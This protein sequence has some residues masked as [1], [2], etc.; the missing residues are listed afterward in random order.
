MKQLSRS[1]VQATAGTGHQISNV[2]VSKTAWLSENLHPLLPKISKRISLITG[3]AT[4]PFKDEAE[5]L[6]VFVCLVIHFDSYFDEI[7][8]PLIPGG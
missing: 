7:L 8:R 4:D 3:L 1:M 5:L 6:Q 2:R